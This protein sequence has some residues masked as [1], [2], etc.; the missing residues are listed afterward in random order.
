M[1]Q[2]ASTSAMVNE[3]F[4]AGNVKNCI[5]F[6]Q[7]ITHCPWTLNAI[8][9]V[10]IPFVTIPTQ[11]RPP[12][13]FRL[14]ESE[15]LILDG[16]VNKLCM[17]GVI[18][19]TL[20]SQGEFISNIFLR[21]KPNGSYRLI[22]DLTQLNLQVQY[23]H[24]KMFS[25]N[26]AIDLITPGAWMASVD[27]KDAYYT[28][29]VRQADRKYLR[30]VWRDLLY[31]FTSLPN[32]LAACPRIFTRLLKPIFAYLSKLGFV[33]FPYIDDSFIIADTKQ[34]CDRAARTLSS[35]FIRCG[36]TLNLEKSFLEPSTK[37]IFLGFWLDSKNMQ[38][39]LT[40]DKMEKFLEH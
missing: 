37:I 32:G 10:N 28:I 21:P 24:F 13:P 17:K 20:H 30:F 18:Q 23:E 25:L 33:L 11:T 39:S 26:T 22:L 14:S 8:Q 36:F 38:V 12:F 40:Q 7:S 5:E 34:K 27:L 29:P 4:I 2:A 3:P 6:W 35:I 31:E 16:E 19:K 9:G 1:Q 15:R